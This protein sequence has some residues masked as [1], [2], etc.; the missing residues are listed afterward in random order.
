M[1]LKLSLLTKGRDISNVSSGPERREGKP[2]KRLGGVFPNETVWGVAA[3]RRFLRT[4]YV[5]LCLYLVCC[6][7]APCE[8]LSF[9]MQ[10][11]HH[12]AIV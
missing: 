9:I 10:L 6:L 1:H 12:C 11:V 8:G 2:T 4:V 5:Q 7:A 3:P